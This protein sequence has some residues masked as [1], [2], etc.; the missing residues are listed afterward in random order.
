MNKISS[1]SSIAF[2]PGYYVKRYLDF[3][4]M[5]QSELAERLNT[6][7]KTV[8][9]LVNGKIDLNNDLIEGLATVF[10]TSKDLWQNLN[11][12]YLE[13]KRQVE[14]EKQF[15][16]EK[17][18]LDKMKYSFWSDNG[19]VKKTRNSKERIQELR[20][21]LHVS[22]LLVLARPNFIVQYKTAVKNV[23]EANIINSNAWVQ[24][25]LNLANEMQVE[26]LDLKYLKSKLPEIRR[27]SL[28]DPEIF[29]PQLK[30]IFAKAGVAFVVVPNLR[31]CGIN[32]AVK[33][34]GKQKVLLAINDRRKDSDIFWFALFHEIKHVFQQKVGHTIVSADKSIGITS[35]LD[36]EKLEQEAD[37]FARDT[38]IDPK[39]YEVFVRKGDFSYNSVV[40][41]SKN[42]GIQPG[43]LVGRL[44]HEGYIGFNRL[45][46][47]KLK[48]RIVFKQENNYKK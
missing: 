14:L 23:K 41:F 43:L 4:Y 44:Q 29:M 13:D 7:E 35:A 1:E 32:G 34:L 24:T 46:G 5:K 27:M 9:Q 37:S 47:L 40:S 39:S 11:N 16:K 31:N 2:H 3:Q 19:F 12:Q 15:N 38:L 33:W 8:S 22:S 30:A 18:I 25:A 17:K 36:L 28:K 10:G 20:N 26:P 45:N 48:Y 21:F 42:I 6:S